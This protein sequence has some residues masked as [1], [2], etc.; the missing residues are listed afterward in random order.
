MTTTTETVQPSI[1]LKR[2]GQDQ[3]KILH[4]CRSQTVHKY[5]LKSSK[6]IL[7]FRDAHDIAN[8]SRTK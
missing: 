4:I 3:D 7:E 8:R 2:V 5:C 6:F 1:P